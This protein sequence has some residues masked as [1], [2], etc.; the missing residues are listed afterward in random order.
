MKIL[1]NFGDLFKKSRVD[2]LPSPGVW[3]TDIVLAQDYK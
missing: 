2:S 1:N 3:G